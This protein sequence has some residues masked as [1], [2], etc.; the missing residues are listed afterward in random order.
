V[1][2]DDVGFFDEPFFQDGMVAQAVR[3][4]VQ[5]GVTYVSAAGNDALTHYQGTFTGVTDPSS[6]DLY[7]NFAV[8]LPSPPDTFERIELGPNQAVACT[9]QW[10]D[11]WDASTN[12]YD[13]ELWDTTNDPPTLIEAST[14]VQ[15][16]TQDPLEELTPL[17]NVGHTVAHV[18]VRVKRVH[19]ASRVL[20]LFCVGVDTIQYDV[21]AGSIFGQPGLTEVVTAGAIDVKDAGLD[22]VEPFSSQGPVSVYFPGQ[23]QRPKP[24]LCGFDDVS[25]SIC[26][27]GAECFDPFVGTSAAAP[28]VAG[29]AALLLSKDPCRTPAEVQSAL[30]AGADDILASGFD[31]VSGAGRLDAL[32]AIGTPGPCDDGN[33]CTA[34]ACKA[35]GGCTHTVVADGTSCAD[36]DLCNGDE[37]C[38]GGTCLPGTPLVCDDNDPCTTDGCDPA[39]G[40]VF[41]PACDDA[42]PCTADTCDPVAGCRHAPVADGTPCPDGNVCNGAETCVAGSCTPGTPLACTDGP[43]CTTGACSR[44]TGCSYLPT[45]G[46]PGV[47]CVCAEGVDPTACPSAPAHVTA[48]LTHACALVA[49]AALAKGARHQRH[50]VASAVQTLAAGMKVTARLQRRGLVAADCGAALGA[51]LRD[52][53]DRAANLRDSL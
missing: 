18:G 36:G 34:D 27:T 44:G 30:R 53:H 11:P 23:E 28:H 5:A 49:R 43:A 45:Q 39:T 8:G 20:A 4:V 9:L 26:P 31:D 47:E 41:T 52:V 21:P 1:I 46:F 32:R 24:D 12:H 2:V 16:G 14:N 19:G 35:G 48:R 13:L 51:V 3:T 42:N 29:V 40:C 22:A 7:H 38:Q 10:N 6:G 50:L 15:S 25:T 33:P 37:V 17:A